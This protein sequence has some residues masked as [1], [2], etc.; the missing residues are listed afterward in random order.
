[1]KTS[2]LAVTVACYW[3]VPLTEVYSGTIK[4]DPKLYI[5]KKETTHI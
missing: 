3:L 1:M 5:L 4:K 2:W